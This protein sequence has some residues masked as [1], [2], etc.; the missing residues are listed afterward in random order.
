M[1][2]FEKVYQVVKKIPKGE[3][4]TYKQVTLISGVNNPRTVGFALHAN[5]N[6]GEIP[7]HRVIKSDGTLA[8]GYAFGGIKKQKEK[9]KNEGVYFLNSEKVDLE[10]SLYKISS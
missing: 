3:V 2:T 7:C 5:K 6:P 9:L 4:L 1:N 10:K 8:K